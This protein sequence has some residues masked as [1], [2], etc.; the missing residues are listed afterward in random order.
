MFF[1]DLIN[2]RENIYILIEEFVRLLF[3]FFCLK[4]IWNKGWWVIYI[5]N[6]SRIHYE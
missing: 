4:W 5:S 3:Y 2:M 1:T 6:F